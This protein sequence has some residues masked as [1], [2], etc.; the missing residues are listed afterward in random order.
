MTGIRRTLARRVRER[1]CEDEG[2][3]V[4]MENLEVDII[5]DIISITDFLLIVQLWRLVARS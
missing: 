4:E 2:T 3:V 1:V 5:V